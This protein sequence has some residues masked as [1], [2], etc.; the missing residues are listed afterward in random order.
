MRI[1]D[2]LLLLFI[3]VYYVSTVCGKE[4]TV[5]ETVVNKAAKIKD[6]VVDG[7]TNIK[8]TVTDKVSGGVKSGAK[9]ASDAAKNAG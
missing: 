2:K 4:K 6:T 8:D 5:K 1:S 3:T 7:A 9:V